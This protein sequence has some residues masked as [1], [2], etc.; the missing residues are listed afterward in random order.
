MKFLHKIFAEFIFLR[1]QKWMIVFVGGVYFLDGTEGLQID[2]TVC[3]FPHA[4]TFLETEYLRKMVIEF[5][6]LD[7][8][9]LL[10]HI[11]FSRA[12]ILGTLGVQSQE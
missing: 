1:F 9:K 12:T 11:S 7:Q 5:Q 3:L 2:I 8:G 4:L 10:F 6:L